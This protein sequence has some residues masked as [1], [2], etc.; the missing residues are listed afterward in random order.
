VPSDNEVLAEA[1]EAARIVST[2]TWGSD[3]YGSARAFLAKMLEKDLREWVKANPPGVADYDEASPRRAVYIYFDSLLPD[4]SNNVVN[5]ILFQGSY[6]EKVVLKVL[7]SLRS[8][9]HK[10][11]KDVV[12]ARFPEYPEL[13]REIR[14]TKK[15]WNAED[16]A[17]RRGDSFRMMGGLARLGSQAGAEYARLVDRAQAMEK[18]SLGK[19]LTKH[20]RAG[21]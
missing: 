3:E 1:R 16:A 13:C 20:T 4:L 2:T 19:I 10:S 12:A 7:Q 5:D 14:E 21:R 8:S 18:S 9:S 17:I 15:R 11:E 6:Y